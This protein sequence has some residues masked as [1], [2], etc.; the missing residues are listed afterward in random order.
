MHTQ[1]GF[2]H[3]LKLA[4]Y[5]YIMNPHTHTHTPWTHWHAHNQVYTQSSSITQEYF[6]RKFPNTPG[7]WPPDAEKIHTSL[8]HSD[9]HFR[10]P[11]E[12]AFQSDRTINSSPVLNKNLPHLWDLCFSCLVSDL[13]VV[14]VKLV[15]WI[16]VHSGMTLFVCRWNGTFLLQAT[17][18]VFWLHSTKWLLMPRPVCIQPDSLLSFFNL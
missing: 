2:I 1:R 9:T 16:Y 13:D 4:N 10:Q 12:V 8:T 6:H 3:Q 5:C 15:E 17:L 7:D 18:V 11:D 14:R